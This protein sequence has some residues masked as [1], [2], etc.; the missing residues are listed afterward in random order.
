MR[1][2]MVSI[3]SLKLLLSIKLN[4]YFSAKLYDHERLPDGWSFFGHR[5]RDNYD[6]EWETFKELLQKYYPYFIFHVL[7]AEI[8][9]LFKLKVS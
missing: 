4:I 8:V 2:V 9:R 5:K 1:L 3:K 7:S 6:N